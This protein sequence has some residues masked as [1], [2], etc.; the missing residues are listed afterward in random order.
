MVSRHHCRIEHGPEGVWVHRPGLL[1]RHAGQRRA[2]RA[3]AGLRAR[4]AAG[5]AGA[6]DG[7]AR[8]AAAAGSG[9][10]VA[11]F[12]TGA[13]LATLT[14]E[15]ARERENLR[16]FARITRELLRETELERLLR[17]IVDQRRGAG[18]RRAR[19]PAPAPRP[20]AA[21]TAASPRS[22]ARRVDA[23]ASRATSTTA[24]SRCRP[25]GSRWASPAGCSS[26][27]QPL[28]S[29]DAGRDERFD[30]MAS[31]EDLRLRSVM[32]LP[33]ARSEARHEAAAARR[34]CSTST[35]ACSRAPSTRRPR[36][37]RAARRPGRDRDPERAPGGRAA[38]AATSACERSRRADRAPERAARAQGA[39]PRHR[40]RGRARASS[41][42]SAGA[43]TTP[44]SSALAT[45]C[46][47]S[48]SSSTGSSSPSCRC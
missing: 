2:G 24:T 47:R 29:V 11:A 38:R 17:L 39:R 36:P 19:L 43:T 44:R 34:A 7:R 40:A 10:T 21:R 15:A 37:G 48:S 41:A 8:R 22:A 13:G 32:C 16:V 1:E 30:G 3:P 33:I 45:A 31:V 35:T 28:L 20:G 26:S 4:P 42:A 12:E 23:C 9:E 27:G 5:R 46:A 18:R 6:L 14:G 25:R